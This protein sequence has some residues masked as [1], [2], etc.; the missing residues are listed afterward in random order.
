MG[1]I[2]FDAVIS[3]IREHSKR[4]VEELD[5]E[6]ILTKLINL[7]KDN[8]FYSI[9]VFLRE[10]LSFLLDSKPIIEY[11]NLNGKEHDFKKW[12][13]EREKE[14]IGDHIGGVKKTIVRN[15]LFEVKLLKGKRITLDEFKN[16]YNVQH[17]AHWLLFRGSVGRVSLVDVEKVK[18][19]E[20][21][22]E[23]YN[24]IISKLSG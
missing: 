22:K 4:K 7:V 19:M 12:L 20:K 2:N 13:I 8:V 5:F 14:I 16:L 1:P 10:S 11:L 3:F 9:N 24:D 17:I 15:F 21:A 23:I 6:G 18:V